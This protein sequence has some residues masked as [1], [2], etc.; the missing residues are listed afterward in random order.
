MTQYLSKIKKNS[1][2]HKY[3]MYYRISYI[4]LRKRTKYTFSVCLP[5]A[6]RVMPV[7]CC[8]KCAMSPDSHTQT[9]FNWGFFPDTVKTENISIGIY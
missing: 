3:C 5:I 2:M 8:K 6:K 4:K 7:I 9:K 1:K